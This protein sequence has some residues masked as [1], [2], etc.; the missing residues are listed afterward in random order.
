MSERYWKKR[1]EWLEFM[2]GRAVLTDEA[3]MEQWLRHTLRVPLHLFKTWKTT[4]GIKTAGDR[5]RL[6]V[7]A[8]EHGD[9]E[10]AGEPAHILYEDDACLV[11]YKPAGMPV[12]AADAAQDKA[13]STLAHAIACHYAWTGQEVRVRHIHRLDA[14]TTGPVLYAKTALSHAIL[15]EAMREKR[16]QRHY[17][18]WV[19]GKVTPVSGT[20]D[21]PIGKDRHH[22]GRRRVTPNGDRA[23]T[24]YEVMAAGKDHDGEETSAVALTLETGRTHQIRVHMSYKGFPLLGDVLY[25]GSSEKLNRQAL[26]GRKLSFCH[27]FGGQHIEIEVPLPDDLERLLLPV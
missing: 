1:G 4:D 6:R 10:P 15:D 17:V 25:G 23:I 24:H 7:F 18:A 2:P 26:H 8:A 11:A 3:H 21:A 14:D 22:R 9:V 5:L 27:P 20:I 16:I 13:R 12:H 19:H